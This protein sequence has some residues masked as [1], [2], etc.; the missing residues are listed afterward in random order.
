[1]STAAAFAALW[2]QIA[3]IGREPGGGHLRYAFS[4]PER[5]LRTW[6]RA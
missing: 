3:P 2:A 4:E 6:F 5:A 1:M